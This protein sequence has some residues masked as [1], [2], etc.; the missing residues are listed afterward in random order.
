MPIFQL[1]RTCWVNKL[2][3]LFLSNQESNGWQSDKNEFQKEIGVES[4][5]RRWRRRR[6][7]GEKNREKGK[8]TTPRLDFLPFSPFSRY[9]LCRSNATILQS[10]VQRWKM[11]RKVIHSILSNEV[12][13]VYHRRLVQSPCLSMIL[14]WERKWLCCENLQGFFF[15][16]SLLFFLHSSQWGSS[17]RVMPR[18]QL[19][20]SFFVFL[21][22]MNSQPFVRSNAWSRALISSTRRRNER[23]RDNVEELLR[24]LLPLF[25]STQLQWSIQ[26]TPTTGLP[27]VI[28]QTRIEHQWTKNLL[29]YVGWFVKKTFTLMRWPGAIFLPVKLSLARWSLVVASER[30]RKS[31]SRCRTPSSTRFPNNIISVATREKHFLPLSQQKSILGSETRIST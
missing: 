22:N 16:S 10:C 17:R 5:R 12:C 30:R 26:T 13:G 27:F 15:F 25:T 1:H 8:K 9:F 31:R 2:P 7:R 11:K 23:E 6:R 28:K 19:E 3:F 21:W 20:N 4:E 14:H 24:A 29:R 18:K